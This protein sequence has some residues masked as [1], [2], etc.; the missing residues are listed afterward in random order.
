MKTLSERV[1]VLS[2]SE[3]NVLRALN[4]VPDR[5]TRRQLAK[6]T[7]LSEVC[8]RKALDRLDSLGFVHG[9]R[10]SGDPVETYRVTPNGRQFHEE[11]IVRELPADRPSIA[12]HPL[13]W[14][15]VPHV[16]PPAKRP[17]PDED[18]HEEEA[19]AAFI[20]DADGFQIRRIYVDDEEGKL[21]KVVVEHL[22]RTQPVSCVSLGTR[23]A[24][25]ELFN[26]AVAEKA[27][28]VAKLR[29]ENEQHTGIGTPELIT[30]L[31][32]AVL[33]LVEAYQDALKGRHKRDTDARV[34]HLLWKFDLQD[35]HNERATRS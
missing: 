1:P 26:L 24:K 35:R 2:A 8:V 27:M 22:S 31:M 11:G 19:P 20:V 5:R 18:D 7:D 10:H 3:R 32:D 6:L 15:I 21:W 23:L 33:E 9:A 17:G 16:K 30:S 14:S 25:D 4:R 29:R 34:A 28:K 13:P 12:G